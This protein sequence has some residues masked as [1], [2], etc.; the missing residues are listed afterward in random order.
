MRPATLLIVHTPHQ[1][2]SKKWA[3]QCD[4]ISLLKNSNSAQFGRWIDCLWELQACYHLSGDFVYCANKI[5]F[6]L[7]NLKFKP[8]GRCQGCTHS[9]GP[10]LLWIPMSYYLLNCWCSCS[11]VDWNPLSL[12]IN[13]AQSLLLTCRGHFWCPRNPEEAEVCTNHFM[14]V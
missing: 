6:L 5:E 2:C 12:C 3:Y 14:M 13:Q 11:F 4:W 9:C 1:L 8:G 10:A 7:V